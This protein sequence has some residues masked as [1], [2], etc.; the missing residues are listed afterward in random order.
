MLFDQRLVSRAIFLGNDL[1]GG[2]EYNE[3]GFFESTETL[4]IND[5]ILGEIGRSW[6][7][8][9]GLQPMVPF[10]WRT[11]R[12][13]EWLDRHY[14]LKAAHIMARV[15]DLRGGRE[16]DPDFGSRMSGTGVDA[17]VG[18]DLAEPPRVAPNPRPTEAIRYILN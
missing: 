9:C 11:T 4:I 7:T 14:P 16:N 15:R 1:I 5:A 17:Q 12:M 2:N 8:L 13:Q 6:D 18:H 3:R 10:W